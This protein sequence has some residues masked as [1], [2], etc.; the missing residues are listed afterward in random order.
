[1]YNGGIRCDEWDWFE[2][3]AVT[4]PAQ[5]DATINAVKSIDAGL[6]KAAGVPEPEIPQR[7][8]PAHQS[9]SARVVK[10]NP[11][12]DPSVAPFVVREIKRT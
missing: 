6:R 8:A 1:M 2:L 4:I 12:A 7:E 3:S 5:A 11:P 9:K 10:L